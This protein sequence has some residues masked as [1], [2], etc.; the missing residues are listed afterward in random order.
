MTHRHDINRLKQLG[1]NFLLLRCKLQGYFRLL[2]FCWSLI[3]LSPFYRRIRLGIEEIAQ[4]YLVDFFGLGLPTNEHVASREVGGSW[5]HVLHHHVFLNDSFIE[6]NL[7]FFLLLGELGV[8][9]VNP[10]V[11]F[12]KLVFIEV[13]QLLVLGHAVIGAVLVR[14]VG[15]LLHGCIDLHFLD[16]VPEVNKQ[17]FAELFPE[18]FEVSDSEVD[19]LILWSAERALKGKYIT[20][21]ELFA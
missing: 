12:A 1:L 6:N 2:G 9:A 10:F 7:G 3:E 13:T 5:S 18:L 14:K 19:I 17:G 16:L 8:L 4:L 21:P 11:D 15:L 20:M